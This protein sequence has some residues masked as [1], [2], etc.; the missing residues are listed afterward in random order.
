[1]VQS[2][3][4]R[5]YCISLTLPRPARGYGQMRCFNNLTEQFLSRELSGASP[6]VWTPLSSFS[7]HTPNLYLTAAF[8]VST[9]PRRTNYRSDRAFRF[10]SKLSAPFA[11]LVLFIRQPPDHRRCLMSVPFWRGYHFPVKKGFDQNVTEMRGLKEELSAPKRTLSPFPFR[12]LTTPAPSIQK[13]KGLFLSFYL[14]WRWCSS[15]WPLVCSTTL[16]K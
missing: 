5:V 10:S 8:T 2:T 13:K 1:M 16:A 6:V 14:C 9:T 11:R 3:N 7:N 12:W 15:I 4:E